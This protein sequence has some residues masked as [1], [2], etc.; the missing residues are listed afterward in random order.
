MLSD[1]EFIK[2]VWKKYRNYDTQLGRKKFYNKD[3]YKKQDYIRKLSQ[4]ATFI[5][6]L[7]TSMGVVYA[8]SVLYEFIQQ[9]GKI[10]YE[11]NINSY[12][13]IG[14]NEIY[15]KSINNYEDYLKYKN[16]WNNIIE[17]TE[18]DFEG[19]FLLV[20][21]A[22][23]RMPDITIENIYTNSDTLYVTVDNQLTEEAKLREEYMVSCMLSNEFKRDSIE[24]RILEKEISSSNYKNLE[25][26]PLEYSSLQAE[27][28]NCIVVID[29]NIS[30]LGKNKI[31][32]FIQ[33]TK[34]EIE[35][36]IRIAIY[37][38]NNKYLTIYDIKYV[39]NQY[40]L[41][42]DY[43]RSK[44]QSDNKIKYIGKYEKIDEKEITNNLKMIYLED[45]FA[46]TIPIII[47]K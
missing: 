36:C 40:I 8:S 29:N 18:K 24:I 19:N 23:W 1:E 13:E 17:M 21:V 26:L 2:V 22:T 20:I 3:F 45:I 14:N 34:K 6:V 9:R 37:E 35:D 15:Y 4:V 25:E 12:F 11:D 27:K 47:Y 5:I 30:N 41:Y 28:D 43:R 38:D 39:D 42:I 16:K 10:N 7:L 33:N 32:T 44:V 31:N 46:K